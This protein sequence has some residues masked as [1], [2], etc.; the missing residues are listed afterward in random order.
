MPL[1]DVV[2]LEKAKQFK[3]EEVGNE[4][5]IWGPQSM[6]A[7][8]EMAAANKALIENA[9]ELSDIDPDRIQVLVRP[10]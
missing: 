9:S 5:L 1:Y 3:G 2:I 4:K 10:F 8:S 7:R 6:I